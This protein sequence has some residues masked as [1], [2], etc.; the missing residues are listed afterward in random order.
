MTDTELR[1]L[2]L[3]ALKKT[4]IS[5]P[6]WLSRL[7]QG[8]YA[9]VTHT[10]WWRAMDALGKIGGQTPPPPP[11]AD[12]QVL[13]DYAL[14]QPL[15]G[16]WNME[17]GNGCTIV[18]TPA[19]KALRSR[20]SGSTAMVNIGQSFE[21]YQLPWEVIPADVWHLFE[22]LI[23]SGQNASYPGAF[24]PSTPGSGWDAVW[25]L[26]NRTDGASGYVQG[27]TRGD[28]LSTMMLVKH[29]GS[30]QV[31]FQ[32]RPAGGT[33]A[34]PVLTF[35][36][37]DELIQRDRWYHHALRLKHGKDTGSGYFEWWVDGAKRHERAIPTAY[38]CNDGKSGERLQAG[39]YRG[40][41]SGETTL[42]H[43]AA[44]VR[45]SRA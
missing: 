15:P 31:R 3:A 30:G 11:P 28:Y 44:T 39:I 24:V 36:Q 32:M 1:D 26:H 2:A 10:E 9:D 12:G 19:G 25:E 4:S 5:Y 21:A 16:P 37:L 40:G 23:P 29:E 43:R 6:N 20:T 17:F 8:K 13:F 34:N 38:L 45:S 35:F 14:N 22:I 42:Y 27:Q 33:L 7:Q 18:D 41:F